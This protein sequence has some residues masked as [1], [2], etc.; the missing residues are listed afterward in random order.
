M[1]RWLKAREEATCLPAELSGHLADM[2]AFTEATGLRRSNVTGLLWSQVGVVQ[3][4]GEFGHG[5]SVC[6]LLCGAS[7]ALC[8]GAERASGRDR[9][10]SWHKSVTGPKTR[11]GQLS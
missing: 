11:K 7:G 2:A 10:R 8:G 3:R 6:S 1:V 4:L 5:A 9:A